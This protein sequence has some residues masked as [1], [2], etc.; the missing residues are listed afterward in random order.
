[1]ATAPSPNDLTRQQL[2]ELDALLQRMLSLPAAPPGGF[3]PPGPAPIVLP[4]VPVARPAYIPPPPAPAPVVVPPVLAPA[5]R[6]DPPAPVVPAPR[7]LP[8]PEP[9]PEPAREPE[10]RASWYEPPTADERPAAVRPA[11]EPEAEPIPEAE[12]EAEPLAEALPDPEPE[13]RPAPTPR[14]Q[15]RPAPVPA[16]TVVP[17]SPVPDPPSANPLVLFN[18][19]L[20]GVLGALGLPGRVAR[21]GFVKN[22]F[23]LAGLGLLAYTGAKVAEAHGWVLLPFPLPWPR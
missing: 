6:P 18:R 3:P 21:S 22:L 13:R 11:P 20:N 8:V 10:P 1:M 4:P 19:G 5:R 16:A 7:L 14:P 15:P 2:D 17:Q 9:E 23:G 12:P